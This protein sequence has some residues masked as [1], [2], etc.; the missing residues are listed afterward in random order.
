MSGDKKLR[1]FADYD[2]ST[3]F[4]P[5]GASIT[6]SGG[7][8]EYFKWKAIHEPHASDGKAEQVVT[9]DGMRANK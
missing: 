9:T 5:C 4:C 6:W 2:T 8:P 7:D 3:C 1:Y